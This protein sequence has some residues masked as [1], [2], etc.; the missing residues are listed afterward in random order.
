[1]RL[2]SIALFVVGAVLLGLGVLWTLQ[3]S[4]AVHLRPILCVSNCKPIGRSP[5]W[6][7]VGIISMLLGLGLII[8]GGRRQQRSRSEP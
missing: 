5:G 6:L 8:V 3:G 4:G 1:M 7:A 2:R